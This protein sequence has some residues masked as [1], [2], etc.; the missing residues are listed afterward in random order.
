MHYTKKVFPNSIFP[1]NISK[2]FSTNFEILN[3]I[4]LN[5]PYHSYVTTELIFMLFRKMRFS[6]CKKNVFEDWM[7]FSKLVNL[8]WFSSL[9]LNFEVSMIESVSWK[10]TYGPIRLGI[11]WNSIERKSSVSFRRL[12]IYVSVITELKWIR[13][14]SAID[15]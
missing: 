1:G 10:T 3:D 13:F 7:N 14:D 2:F 8:K 6:K 9:P 12:S 15:N 4:N 5:F 11:L